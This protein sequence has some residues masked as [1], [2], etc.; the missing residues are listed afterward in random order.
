MTKR[1]ISNKEMLRLYEND[2][3]DRMITI[4][5]TIIAHNY[6]GQGDNP[7]GYEVVYTETVTTSTSKVLEIARK[8]IDYIVEK[9]ITL[10]SG[11][12]HG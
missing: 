12:R 7:Q 5:K 8:P 10:I 9:I 2:S 11:N 4:G 3:L 1:K 6:E